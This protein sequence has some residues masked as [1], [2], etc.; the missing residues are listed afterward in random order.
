MGGQK[1]YYLNTQAIQSDLQIQLDLDQNAM[2][3]SELETTAKN[4]RWITKHPK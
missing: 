3:F 1:Q 4:L 2:F